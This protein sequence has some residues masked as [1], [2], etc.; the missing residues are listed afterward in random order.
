MKILKISGFVLPETS[1]YE[2]SG[3]KHQD[4]LF[5]IYNDSKGLLV[6]A[7]NLIRKLCFDF[8]KP[9]RSQ[10]VDEHYKHIGF[11]CKIKYINHHCSLKYYQL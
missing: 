9:K 10:N 4:P 5:H 3:L 6:I 11:F 1:L 8:N 2:M 7:I